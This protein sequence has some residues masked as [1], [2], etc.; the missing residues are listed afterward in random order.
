PPKAVGV[1]VLVPVPPTEMRV[2]VVVPPD[3]AAPVNCAT[4][5][6]VLSTAVLIRPPTRVGVRLGVGLGPAVSLGAGVSV[7][8][9]RAITGVSVTAGPITASVLVGSGV[10][11]GT[12][13]SVAGLAVSTA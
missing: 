11:D 10:S 13:V 3:G 6:P 4:A 5:V 8:A 1:A 12:G 9:V 7:G 2:G